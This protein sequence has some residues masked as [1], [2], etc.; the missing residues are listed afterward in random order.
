[1]DSVFEDDRSRSL[2]L[3][4]IKL[5]TVSPASA[6]QEQWWIARAQ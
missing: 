1:M 2:V 5:A 4:A 6:E 3:E